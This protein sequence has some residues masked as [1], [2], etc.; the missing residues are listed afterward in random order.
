MMWA[1]EN[2]KFAYVRMHQSIFNMSMNEAQ[3][4]RNEVLL[5]CVNIGVFEIPVSV[6]SLMMYETSLCC[7]PAPSV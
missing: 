5:V 1:C 6:V 3:R 2:M 4:K 7:T